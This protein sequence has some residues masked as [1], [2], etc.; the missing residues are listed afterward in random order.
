MTDAE[1]KAELPAEVAYFAFFSTRSTSAG[2]GA[3]TV[4]QDVWSAARPDGG[5]RDGDGLHAPPLHLAQRQPEHLVRHSA[6]GV[7]ERPT[8]GHLR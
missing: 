2:R 1:I 8:H 5:L 4:R 3:A 7:R 6:D